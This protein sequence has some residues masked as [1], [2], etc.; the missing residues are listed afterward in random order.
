MSKLR[1]ARR[2][3]AFNQMKRLIGIFQSLNATAQAF[4]TNVQNIAYV[5]SGKMISSRKHYFRYLLDDIEVTTD[6]LGVLTVNEYDELCENNLRT[7]PTSAMSRKGMKYK[8]RI[9]VAPTNPKNDE[10]NEN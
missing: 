9:Y 1:N 7:Y 4:G 6:D 3:L 8:K 5:C 2:V 10:T